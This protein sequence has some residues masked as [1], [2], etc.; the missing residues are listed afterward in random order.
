ML[1]RDIH[2]R[3]V[4]LWR[5]SRHVRFTKIIAL[6]LCVSP[7]SS[8]LAGSVTVEF[9]GGWTQ[10]PSLVRDSF[11]GLFDQPFGGSFTYDTEPVAP[12]TFTIFDSTLVLGDGIDTSLVPS[13][14]SFA[15]Q[16]RYSSFDNPFIR[17]ES[18]GFTLAVDSDLLPDMGWPYLFGALITADDVFE[19]DEPPFQLPF[20]LDRIDEPRGPEMTVSF[21]AL[22]NVDVGG[23]ISAVAIQSIVPEPPAILGMLGA[24]LWQCAFGRRRS[25]VAPALD[26]SSVLF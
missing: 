16:V 1:H 8:V 17:R 23:V 9:A 21:N 25:N 14:V 19:E 7:G 11:G 18:Y 5:Q 20:L 22:G 12:G 15:N 6:L 4:E 10:I 13:T 2:V 3:E 24:A 26:P